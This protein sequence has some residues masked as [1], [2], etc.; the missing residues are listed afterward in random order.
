MLFCSPVLALE[1]SRGTLP[2][3]F[4][5]HVAWAMPAKAGYEIFQHAAGKSLLPFENNVFSFIQA[6]HSPWLRIGPFTRV[7]GPLRKQQRQKNK[8]FY[9]TFELNISR[10]GTA[11][12]RG[13]EGSCIDT[14]FI[15]H[16]KTSSSFMLNERRSFMLRQFGIHWIFLP[17]VPS[18]EQ[19][20]HPC[21]SALLSKTVG[22]CALGRGGPTWGHRGVAYWRPTGGHRGD[23]YPAFPLL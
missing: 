5:A 18:Q 2:D 20:A 9:P 17:V 15:Q 12:Y 10:S 3:H 22:D 11:L 7:K 21:C 23:Q 8:R 16:E 4:T 19:S 1:C 6:H 14:F 13:Q